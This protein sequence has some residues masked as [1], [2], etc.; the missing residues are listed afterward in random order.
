MIS[1]LLDAGLPGDLAQ[2]GGNPKE[3]GHHPVAGEEK[4]YGEGNASPAR[5]T[6]LF[7]AGRGVDQPPHDAVGKPEGLLRPLLLLFGKPFAGDF[8]GKIRPGNFMGGSFTN[9]SVAFLL[10]FADEAVK[11]LIA[12]SRHSS[13]HQSGHH[14]GHERMR[15]LG[16]RFGIALE[17]IHLQAFGAEAGCRWKGAFLP[18]AFPFNFRLSGCGRESSLWESACNSGFL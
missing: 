11:E 18:G 12:L 6:R 17:H 14:S 3:R 8:T 5:E 10:L 1:E 2:G 15:G 9:L 7:F 4:G 13:R 16:G